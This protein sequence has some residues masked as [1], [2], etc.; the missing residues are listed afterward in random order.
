MDCQDWTPVVIG[1]NKQRQQQQER[2]KAAAEA[3][4]RQ[5]AISKTVRKAL[6][7]DGQ[8]DK[9]DKID[10]KVS[11]RIQQRRSEKGLSRKQLAQQLGVKETVLASYENGSAI[12]NA[13]LLNKME[14]ILGKSV[15]RD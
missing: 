12:P 8:P 3:S 2:K 13:Q 6:Q 1:R 5:S 4:R 14:R 10:K 15:R 11:Q 7:D 9:I